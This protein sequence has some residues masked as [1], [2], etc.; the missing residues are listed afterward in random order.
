MKTANAPITEVFPDK[1]VEMLKTYFAANERL[2]AV[3][4]EEP[5][6][7]FRPISENPKFKQLVGST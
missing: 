5:G 1:A 7:W 2:R 4:A 3:Y 6:W